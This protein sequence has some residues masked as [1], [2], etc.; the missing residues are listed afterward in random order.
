MNPI[1]SLPL[2]GR[3]GVGASPAPTSTAERPHP[4]LPSE[5]EGAK[6]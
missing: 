5:G 1:R 3:A 6:Q 2:R 4:D